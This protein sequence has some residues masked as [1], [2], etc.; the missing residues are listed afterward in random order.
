MRID[1]GTPT[2]EV[3]VADGVAWVRLRREDRANALDHAVEEG[4][5]RV[6]PMLDA[7]PAVRVVV[8]TGSGRTF[9]A[10]ADVRIMA[11][12]P[13]RLGLEPGETARLREQERVRLTW[14]LH[15]VV[16]VAELSRPTIAA[17][18]GAAAGAGLALAC[19]CD[20]RI[21]ADTAR[22]VTAYGRLA[23][24]GDWGLTHLLP[25]LVGPQQTRRMLLLGED[26]AA[27]DAV[28]MGLVDEVVAGEALRLRVEEFARVLAGRSS[29]AIAETKGLLRDTQV[30]RRVVAAEIEATLRCQ[31]TEDHRH[32]LEAFLEGRQPTFMPEART[33]TTGRRSSRVNDH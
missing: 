17:I 20:F 32:A 23:L 12:R 13:R 26:V 1:T 21:A 30:L 4:L 2:L 31:E 8:L 25:Q 19:A 15:N 3:E 18:N 24:P 27:E 14:A 16:R 6:L 22:F 9:C 5:E 7:M 29:T 33:G 28:A 11:D 10:G